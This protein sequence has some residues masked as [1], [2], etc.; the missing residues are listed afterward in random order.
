MAMIWTIGSEPKLNSAPQATI[1]SPSLILLGIELP[2]LGPASMNRGAGGNG[3][4]LILRGCNE[5][6]RARVSDE[7]RFD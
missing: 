7:F 5:A 1:V 4:P 2:R 3:A 6:N